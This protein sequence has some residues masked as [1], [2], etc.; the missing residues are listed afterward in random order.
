MGI[1]GRMCMGAYGCVWYRCVYRRVFVCECVCALLLL[2]L[3]SCYVC[4]R[5]SNTLL[6]TSR[7]SGG[8][9]Q[10]YAR[11]H[12][13]VTLL[14]TLHTHTTTTTIT[15]THTHTHTLQHLPP[16]WA[17]IILR[18]QNIQIVH[19]PNYAVPLISFLRSGALL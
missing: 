4:G 14:H 17:R 11:L 12:L 16:Q 3:L 2:L 19:I 8:R 15:Y 1:Y 10:I 13:T 5:G 7:S 6:P 18:A 9:V